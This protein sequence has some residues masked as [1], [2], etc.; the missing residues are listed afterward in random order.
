MLY[1]VPVQSAAWARIQTVTAAWEPLYDC[2]T[3]RSEE[4]T[5]VPVIPNTSFN[6]KGEPIVC[7]PADALSAFFRNG[8]E[9]LVIDRFIVEKRNRI[10]GSVSVEVVQ[11]VR[12]SMAPDVDRSQRL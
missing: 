12:S 10:P 4:A 7:S 8:L 2:L 1:T 5:G 3:R 11:D 6:L 9:V